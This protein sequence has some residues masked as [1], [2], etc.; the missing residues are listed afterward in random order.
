MAAFEWCVNDF[1][2]QV[3]DATDAFDDPLDGEK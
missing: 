1:I 2:A 3:I